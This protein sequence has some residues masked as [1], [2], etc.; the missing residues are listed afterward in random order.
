MRAGYSNCDEYR[1]G[2]DVMQKWDSRPDKP[3][4]GQWA[5]LGASFLIIIV[6]IFVNL[7]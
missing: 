6:V 1:G 2:E 5:A 3:D 7:M 4:S